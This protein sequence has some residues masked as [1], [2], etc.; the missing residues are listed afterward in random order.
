MSHQYTK[1]N[2]EYYRTLKRPHRPIHRYEIP[3]TEEEWEALL[4][5]VESNVPSSSPA[6]EIIQEGNELGREH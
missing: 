1:P 2:N 3:L 5:W 4:D 6:R